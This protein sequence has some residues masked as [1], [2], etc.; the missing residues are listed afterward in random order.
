MACNLEASRV[1]TQPDATLVKLVR[2]IQ[3]CR[4][5]HD[6][7]KDPL[8]HKPNPV[9]QVSSDARIMV[10]GQAPG[11][12]VHRSG[13]PF[14]DPSGDR[15]RSWMGIGNDEFYDPSKLAIVPMGFCF[16]GFD[17]HGGDQPPRKECKS[18][19]HGLLMPNLAQVKL[20]LMIGRYAQDYHCPEKRRLSLTERVRTWREEFYGNHDVKRIPL[21]HPSWR[22]NNWLK[23]NPWFESDVLPVLRAE[24]QRLL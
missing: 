20:I 22:N 1:T 2:E 16:P 3:S 19:W 5:C 7:P 23:K 24:I 13:R 17:R 11:I 4:Y 21:P 18:R 9:L 15:L 12:R 6:L 8:P 14:T 10:C